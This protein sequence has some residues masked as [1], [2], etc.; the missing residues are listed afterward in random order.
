[1]YIRTLYWLLMHIILTDQLA[2]NTKD[3]LLL[4]IQ[5]ANTKYGE[6]STNAAEG[7]FSWFKKTIFGTYHY[8]SHKPL[9]RYCAMLSYIYNTRKFSE[10]LRSDTTMAQLKGRL[11]YKNLIA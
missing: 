5:W 1:M 9:Q 7:A 2:K 4:I 6:Y 8:V 10:S 3:T 11:T